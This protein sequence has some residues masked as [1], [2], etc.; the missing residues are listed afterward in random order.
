MFLKET[1]VTRGKHRYVYVQLVEGYR[2]EHGRVRQR[3]VANL[4]RR[5]S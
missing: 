2:D 4:G 1:A 3:V 5:R